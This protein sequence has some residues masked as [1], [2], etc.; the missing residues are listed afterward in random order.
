MALPFDIAN[1][2]LTNF[3]NI[4]PDVMDSEPKDV[5]YQYKDVDGNIQTKT[6]ANRGKFKQ[7]LWDDVGGALGQFSRTFYVDAENGDDNND[8]SSDAPFKTIQKAVNSV[9]YGA[10]V[11]VN[12]V[13]DYT[14]IFGSYF[15]NIY[16][17]ISTGKTW[18]IP[19][20]SRNLINGCSIVIINA[21]HLIVETLDS[22]SN[23]NGDNYAGFF[24]TNYEGDIGLAAPTNFYLVNYKTDNP[25]TVNANRC[26]FGG[27]TWGT[28]QNM[29]L[30]F[31]TY[32]I[33]CS[34]NIT[35]DGGLLN[36]HGG[37]GSFQWYSLNND[38]SFKVVD[39]DGNDVDIK[40]KV[41]G[42]VKDSDSGNP[43]NLISAINFSD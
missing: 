26:L 1:F 18:T 14:G 31:A 19:D 43:I 32:N 20:G 11:K 41:G 21:G 7:Q 10:F 27:R 38:D 34:G 36:L 15:K 17:S 35:L 33:Y 22:N 24:A 40:T 30:N 25:L 3:A 9:P 5:T 13:S 6:I 37:V 4:Y 12:L 16:I 2:N 23:V 42:I 39:S 28:N 29:M 8:G